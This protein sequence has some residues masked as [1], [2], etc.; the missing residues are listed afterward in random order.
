[1][2]AALK[3]MCKDLSKAHLQLDVTHMLDCNI[4]LSFFTNENR[5]SEAW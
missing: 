4:F 2:T 1:M 5:E 3:S